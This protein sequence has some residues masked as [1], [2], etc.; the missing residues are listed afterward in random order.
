MYIYVKE[1]KEVLTITSSLRVFSFI[2]PLLLL[3]LLCLLL[4]FLSLISSS[5]DFACSIVCSVCY[6]IV[7]KNTYDNLVWDLQIHTQIICSRRSTNM[8][9]FLL[10]NTNKKEDFFDLKYKQT[11]IW[12]KHCTHLQIHSVPQT[13]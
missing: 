11:L 10:T 8:Y 3:L 5:G 2:L 9:G 12:K 6:A 7:N 4:L 1:R 13:V